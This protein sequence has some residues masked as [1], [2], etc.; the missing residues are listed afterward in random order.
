MNNVD[1]IEKRVEL[2]LAK[3]DK[4][5]EKVWAERLKD[6]LSTLSLMFEKYQQDDA[7]IT[8]T[9]FNKYNRLTKELEHIEQMLT[10]DY[11]IIAQEVEETREAIYIQ[12]MLSSVYLFSMASDTYMPFT[13]PTTDTITNAVEQPIEFIKLSETLEKQRKKVLE[14][15]RINLAQGIIAGEG[16][17]KIAQRLRKDIG[18]SSHQAKMV[19]RTEG[20]RTFSQSQLDSID[21]A[22]EYGI[23]ADKF[24]NATKDFRTRSSHRHMDGKNSDKNGIFTVNGCK[25]L[26]PKMLYG[27]NSAGENINCRCTIGY[28]VDGEYPDLMRV[29]DADNKT[30][31]VPY[32]PFKEWY[33]DEMKG[34][35][36]KERKRVE[37]SFRELKKLKY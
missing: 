33:E 13:V 19:A 1:D 32:K 5:I 20:G 31:V 22:K 10:D 18:M 34:L 9:E 36:E 28:L 14:R 7:H 24:W 29:R 8:W 25:G 15:I 21:K 17:N 3:A 12:S 23:G 2:L 30:R 16:Y 26:A 27:V 4:T 11:K 37:K 35:S 6:I